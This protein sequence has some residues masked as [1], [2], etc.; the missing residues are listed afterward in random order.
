MYVTSMG[1][2]KGGEKRALAPLE[3]GNK[4]QKFL[5]NVKSAV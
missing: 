4:T 5:E 3:I 2:R 1:V